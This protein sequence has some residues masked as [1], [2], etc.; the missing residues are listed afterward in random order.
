MQLTG[1]GQPLRNAVEKAGLSTRG[2]ADRTREI[3][4]YGVA[5]SV[6]GHLLSTGKS[7]RSTCSRRS[8]DYIT[9]VLADALGEPVEGLFRP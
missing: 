6:I 1:D 5:Q 7:H 8:A 2:I 3:D 9:R 4:G